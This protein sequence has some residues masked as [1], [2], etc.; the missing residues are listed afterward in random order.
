MEAVKKRRTISLA[1]HEAIWAYVLISPWIVGFILFTGGPMIASLVFSLSR[2]DIAKPLQ[3]IG[4][5]NYVKV[6]TGDPKFWHSL[7]VTVTYA[8]VAI[9]IFG[10]VVTPDG[11]GITMW[12]ISVPMIVLYFAAYIILRGRRP[13]LSAL[14]DIRRDSER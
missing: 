1:R 4:F 14:K 13:A 2:Y 9:V 6:F 8:V 10:T 11:S 5:L 12:L 3:F 7:Q